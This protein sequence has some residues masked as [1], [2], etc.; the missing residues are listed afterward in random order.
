MVAAKLESFRVL[1]S[2]LGEIAKFGSTNESLYYSAN[3]EEILVLARKEARRQCLAFPSEDVRCAG[4]ALDVIGI[5]NEV[6][7]ADLDEKGKW[8]VY[9]R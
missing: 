7:V 4:Y 3:W 1:E 8:I 6:S 5:P 9:W 2:E